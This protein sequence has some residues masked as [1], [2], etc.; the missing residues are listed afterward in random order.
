VTV[1][2]KA[3]GVDLCTI[4]G[5]KFGCPK[6]VA[7]LFVKEGTP[8]VPMFFGGGQ[9]AGRRAGTENVLLIVAIGAISGHFMGICV[10]SS[11][12]CGR[13]WAFRG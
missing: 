4:V 3:L 7:A 11:D 8:Y 1:D 13:I 2:A 9:E 5:H 10:H 6:G 12:I